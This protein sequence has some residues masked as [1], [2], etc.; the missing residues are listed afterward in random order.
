[1]DEFVERVL[2][3]QWYLT[4][5]VNGSSLP[6]LL[7]VVLTRCDSSFFIISLDSTHTVV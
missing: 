2:F 1:M 3:D 6:N 5:E 4:S 7:I